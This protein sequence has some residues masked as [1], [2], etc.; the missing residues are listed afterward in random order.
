MIVLH[1][2]ME[3]FFI[4]VYLH[5]DVY[6][7]RRKSKG[8]RCTFAFVLCFLKK[9]YHCSLL[10]QTVTQSQSSSVWIGLLGTTA[11]P[12]ALVA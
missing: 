1:L 2:L 8:N 12:H 4:L 11:T 5:G 7:A 6:P 10:G 3:P 9:N